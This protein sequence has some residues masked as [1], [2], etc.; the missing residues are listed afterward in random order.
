MAFV[1]MLTTMSFAVDLHYC[2]ETMVDF[3]FLHK[4]E[5]CG[6]EKVLAPQPCENTVSEKSCCSDEQ[7]VMDGH[8][9]LKT[10]YHTLTFEQQ[11]FIA[12]FLYSYINSFEASDVNI[13]PFKAY[14]PPFL[15]HDVQILHE[16]YLI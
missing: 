1:V 9:D 11:T 14:S 4:V 3:S 15:I 8:N 2:G 16:T 5:T 7:I 13:I 6:M 12:S 10:S